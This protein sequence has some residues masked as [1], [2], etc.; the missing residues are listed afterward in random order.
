MNLNEWIEIILEIPK[1]QIKLIESIYN[2]NK[3]IIVVLSNGAPITMEWKDKA[4]LL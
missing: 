2:V 3:N 4:K 1:N